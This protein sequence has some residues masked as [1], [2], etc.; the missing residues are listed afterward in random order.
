MDGAEETEVTL[1]QRTREAFGTVREHL[2]HHEL[3]LA[4]LQ[5]RL[6]AL[7]RQRLED[8]RRFDAFEERLRAQRLPPM[9]SVP[10]VVPPPAPTGDVESLRALVRQI[11][12]EAPPSLQETL[13][14]SRNAVE[15]AADALRAVSSPEVE[16]EIRVKVPRS[17]R[18]AEDLM[19]Q[20][21]EEVL[22]ALARYRASPED[23]ELKRRTLLRRDV[24]AIVDLCDASRHSEDTSTGFYVSLEGRLEA[25]LQQAELQSISPQRGDAYDPEEHTA[26]DL[27]QTDDG[28]LRDKVESCR[29]RGYK[30]DGELLKKA[31]V[32][33]YR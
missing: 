13:R 28:R 10:V 27:I 29:Y 14:A 33:I 9:M 8:Q 17:E 4:G 21:Q 5:E 32:V 31:G 23:L 26:I 19:A 12:Q 6:E 11:C 7:E 20:V 18:M 24:P 30:H 1:E 25:L 2:D 16:V 22:R 3:M 15:E